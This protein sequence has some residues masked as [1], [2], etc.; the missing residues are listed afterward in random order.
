MVSSLSII[1][2]IITLLITTLF[3][4][5]FLLILLKGHKGVF[6]V[7]IAGALG[8]IVTQVIIRIP[9]LQVLGTMP[10]VQSFARDQPVFYLL[11]LA[12]TAGLFETVGR[13]VVLRFVLVK[14]LSFMTGLAGGAGHGGIESIVLLGMTYVNNLIIAIMI[15]RGMLGSIIPDSNQMSALIQTMTGTEPY[16]FFLAGVERIFTMIFHIAMYVLLAWFVTRK[17]SAAGFFLVA[18]I[19]GATD[20]IAPLMQINGA[21][22]LAIE[23]FLLAVA[24]LSIILVLYLRPRFGENQQIPPDPAEQAVKEGY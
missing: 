7:W 22:Y 18:G 13:L 15:N 10:F 5:I 20:F 21:S 6:S 9:L 19:H 23:G 4:I 24:I 14:R 11:I 12:L 1:F 16:L 8:F 3:P 2:I 17:H